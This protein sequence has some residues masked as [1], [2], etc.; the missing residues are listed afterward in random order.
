MRAVR[1]PPPLFPVLCFGNS[2]KLIPL[3]P[4]MKS[5][6]DGVE[7][8]IY[9]KH[10]Y[11]LRNFHVA[12]FTNNI[13]LFQ[14]NLILTNQR[15]EAVFEGIASLINR[16]ETI[17]HILILWLSTIRSIRKWPNFLKFDL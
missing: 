17:V 1:L 8:C 7:A 11:H 9:E 12:A 10:S 5:T 16:H 3:I 15:H 14:L 6:T 13:F 2:G 4:S